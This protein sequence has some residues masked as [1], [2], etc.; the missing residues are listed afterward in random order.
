MKAKDNT[1]KMCTNASAIGIEKKVVPYNDD[2]K[3]LRSELKS[4]FNE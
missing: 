2:R 1:E 4:K 3:K